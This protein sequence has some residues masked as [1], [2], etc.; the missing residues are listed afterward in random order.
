M[1]IKIPFVL[2]AFSLLFN[3]LF[4]LFLVLSLS[5]KKAFFSFDRPDGYTAAAAVASVPSSGEIVFGVIEIALKPGEKAYLQYSVSTAGIIQANIAVRALYDPE[6][7]SV[8]DS[9]YGIEILAL[10]Q[11]STLMQTLSNDGI[12]DAALV[13]VK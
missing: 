5:S 2:S 1:K 9:G 8:K 7:I 10:A 12:K 13:T 11:G 6:I 3:A 4:V